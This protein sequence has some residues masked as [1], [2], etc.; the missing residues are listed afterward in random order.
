VE[1]ALEQNEEV[2]IGSN[3]DPVTPNRDFRADN[4]P[5]G[6]FRQPPKRTG[7]AYVARDEDAEE[8]SEDMSDESQGI[9]EDVRVPVRDSFVARE[10]EAPQ[11]PTPVPVTPQVPDWTQRLADEVYRVV[12]NMGWH[13]PPPRDPRPPAPREPRQNP[14][15]QQQRRDNPNWDKF[16]EKCLRWGHVEEDCWKDMQCGRCLETGHPTHMCREI[17]CENCGK[18]HLGNPCEDWKTLEN[19]KNRTRFQAIQDGDGHPRV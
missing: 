10:P 13:P 14:G 8:A 19:S 18:L 3:Q 1:F 6:R 7:R 4:V 15:F 5:Q 17:P 2:W 9:D 11:A 16:C 12:D